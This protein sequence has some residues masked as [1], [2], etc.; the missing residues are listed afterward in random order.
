MSTPAC[1]CANFLNTHLDAGKPLE[2]YPPNTCRE[3]ARV[4]LVALTGD[5]GSGLGN[6]QAYYL[7]PSYEGHGRVST[8]ERMWVGRRMACLR[9]SLHPGE[10]RLAL[11][12]RAAASKQEEMPVERLVVWTFARLKL[13]GI[14]GEPPPGVE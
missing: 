6:Q 1:P 12:V 2:P 13:K 8:T 7:T 4:K 9:Y 5:S 11:V 3:T 14:D 10:S